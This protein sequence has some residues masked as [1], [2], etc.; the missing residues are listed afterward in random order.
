MGTKPPVINQNINQPSDPELASAFNLLKK[1]TKTEIFCH[2]IGIIQAF[3]PANQTASVSFAYLKTVF[4]ADADGSY[5]PNTQ[6]YA[7]QV[8]VPVL[9]LG[10]GQSALTFPLAQ[11]DECLLLFNDRDLSMWFASGQVVANPTPRLHS[12]SDAVAIVGF[13]SLKNSLKKF[14]LTKPTT[15]QRDNGC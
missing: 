9:F 13:R 7:L 2:A 1:E 5:S 8:Q 6:P 4:V 11:G 14:Q 10:G 12:A 3:N 15:L